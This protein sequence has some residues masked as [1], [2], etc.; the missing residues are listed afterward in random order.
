MKHTLAGDE[1][2]RQVGKAFQ[3]EVIRIIA[4]KYDRKTM[5]TT[6]TVLFNWSQERIQKGWSRGHSRNIP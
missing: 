4:R 5:Q 2:R 3:V 1:R 6:V